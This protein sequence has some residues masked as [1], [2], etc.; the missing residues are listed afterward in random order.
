MASNLT[1]E[2]QMA[3]IDELTGSATSKV[4]FNFSFSS[5]LFLKKIVFKLMKK[6]LF[7]LGHRLRG[8]IVKNILKERSSRKCSSFFSLTWL[9]FLCNFTSRLFPRHR[10]INSHKVS[11]IFIYWILTYFRIYYTYIKKT[12]SDLMFRGLGNN[13]LA[14]K[15]RK[16]SQVKEKNNV[17]FV[18]PART[19]QFQI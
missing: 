18:T 10:S 3:L 14:Q 2:E 4:L 19:L 13:A 7:L 1:A 5:C 11:L 16:A 8:R 12:C 9:A 6:S 15:R 17:L